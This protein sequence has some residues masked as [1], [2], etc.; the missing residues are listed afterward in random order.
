M[1]NERRVSKN[2]FTDETKETQENETDWDEDQE[3]KKRYINTTNMEKM[4]NHD[5][6]LKLYQEELI[7]RRH[8]NKFK[9]YEEDD[10]DT[11]DRKWS[12]WGDLWLRQWR[13]K[14]AT[15]KILLD[16]NTRHE[17]Y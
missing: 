9:D 2:K 11:K 8:A 16:L 15:I 14:I 1:K 4:E 10:T 6:D 5:K 7:R 13:V 12:T 17:L 3:I